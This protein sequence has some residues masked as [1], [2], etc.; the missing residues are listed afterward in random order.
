[1]PEGTP[2]NAP[3]A[4]LTRPD[5]RRE[6]AGMVTLRDALRLAVSAFQE[7]GLYYGHG[8]ATAVDEAVFM[9]LES[10]N[11]P[12]D[13]FNAFADA[14]LTDREK[15]LLGERLALRIEK[16]L[17][18]AYITGRSYLLGLPFRSDARALVPRSYIA[19]LLRSPLFDGSEPA[20]SLI[21]DPYEVTSVL[22]LCTGG[23]SLAIFAAY[24]FPN[25]AVDAVDLSPEALSLAAENLRY[26]GLEDRITLL[27]GDLFAPV[28]GKTYDL[29][30]TNP[31]YVGPEVM[32]VLPG[33]F[34]HEPQM[35]LAGGGGDGLD[36]VRRIIEEC[37]AHLNPEGGMLCE[38]GEDH[39]ILD[40]DYPD[41]E[42]LWLDSEDSA[43][44][45]FWLPAT[46]QWS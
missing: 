36:L 18:A 37:R 10:L 9:I 32:G 45:V 40:E 35:A 21:G 1:M 2:L 25:A 43:S 30:I 16:R 6:M 22:D 31:P 7:A 3:F 8:S 20:Q 44:E 14:R 12:V 23:G 42:F 11:L 17:P 46:S 24:A 28:K 5:L 29:I 19:E 27:Q 26:H 13:D 33:E 41:C 4:E 15:T 39:D 38:M 34:L